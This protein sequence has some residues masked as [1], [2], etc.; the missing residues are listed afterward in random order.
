MT[1]PGPPAARTVH[2]ERGSQNTVI[3]ANRPALYH[4]KGRASHSAMSH[5]T[6]SHRAKAFATPASAPDRDASATMIPLDDPP[7]ERTPASSWVSPPP[8]ER[9]PGGPAP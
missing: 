9:A 5:G 4:E 1:P 2:P 8:E 7:P 6:A 3:A